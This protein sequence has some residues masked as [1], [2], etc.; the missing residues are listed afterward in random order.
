MAI[1]VELVLFEDPDFLKL[2]SSTR[3]FYVA[4]SM[5]VLES[6]EQNRRIEF[7]TILRI[8]GMD[9]IQSQEAI[10]EL[11]AV[12][13]LVREGGK[14]INLPR[15]EIHFSRQKKEI[16]KIPKDREAQILQVFRHWQNVHKKH[17]HR[18]TP[19]RKKL[20]YQRLLDGYTVEN[21]VMAIDGCKIS[22]YHQGQNDRNTIYDDL[23]LILR[24]GDK[25][26]KFMSY[27]ENAQ[28]QTEKNAEMTV[29]KVANLNGNRSA[30]IEEF[31]KRKTETNED[32]VMFENFDS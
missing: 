19:T 17:Q 9:K 13:L 11:E 2:S 24:N 12:G 7:A 27:A 22:P 21:L 6:G 31:R 14:N 8:V 4:L 1:G 10:K 28:R 16:S 32:L 26:E 3:W 20:I 15:A 23:E 25:L 18:L 5:E 30:I 29:K